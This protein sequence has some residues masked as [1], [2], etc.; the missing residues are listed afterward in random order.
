[1][2]LNPVEILKIVDQ[3]D[4]KYF[5][6]QFTDIRGTPKSVMIPRN[7]LQRVLE[8]GVLFDGSSILGYATIEESDMRAFPDY[9]SFEILP[10]AIDG[11]KAARLV[12]SIM[13]PD[14]KPF[15]G[16]PRYILQKQLE[17]LHNRGME[18]F[19]GPE[20]EFFLLEQRDGKYVP[21][22]SGGYFTFGPLDKGELVKKE[23]L[24]YL[25]VLGYQPEAAHH[26]VSPGQHEIDLRY[27]PALAMADRIITMRTA[28][29]T[30]AAKFGLYAT[31]MPKPFYGINGTGMHIHQSI[32]T[33]SED[34]N[35]FW[36]Q[37]DKYGLSD[38]AYHYLAGVLKH[39][40]EISSIIASWVNSYKRLVP[41]Y[42]APVYIAW[43]RKNRSAMIRIPAGEGIKKR[44]EFRAPDSSGNP[45]LQFAVI[46]GAGL[47]GVDKKLECPDPVEQDIF[48]LTPKE[49]EKMQ[50][51]Q[52]PESLGEALHHLRNSTLMKDI[53]GEHIYKN[54]LFIKQKEWDD[55]RSYVTDWEINNQ[56]PIL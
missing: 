6:F 36:D 42:E 12:C 29:K 54:F 31:F 55:F 4:I 18:F 27:A 14:G 39:S 19:V 44:L 5:Y 15:M 9:N 45:Y 35:F 56:L 47:D 33:P 10:W 7:R 16:D 26:E 41:G 52:L 17:K 51:D 30:V 37:N 20:F 8:E 50:I 22:D 13:T 28:I 25:E 53:L 3:N 23:I 1:M 49:R 34:K 48:K 2:E 11:G 43:G 46:L 38:F 40:V 32:M 21:H 24:N